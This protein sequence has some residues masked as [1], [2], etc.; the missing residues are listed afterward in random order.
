MT[1]TRMAS[2]I[3][4]LLLL[5]AHP[6][7]SDAPKPENLA[8]LQSFVGK[9]PTDVKLWDTQPLGDRLKALLGQQLPTF[10]VNMRV[11][12]PIARSGNV[13]WMSGSKPHE[14]ATDGALLLADTKANVMEVYLLSKGTLT[15]HAESGAAIR[16]DGDAK[17]VLGNLQDA[18]EHK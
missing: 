2:T 3:A 13:V 17:K 5:G 16:V 9:Y 8:Y 18:A 14:G 7:F 15:H 6:S 1:A 4:V 10:L 11:N 12:G